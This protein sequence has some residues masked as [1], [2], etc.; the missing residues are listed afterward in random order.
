[1]A[2]KNTC[3]GEQQLDVKE[4][5]SLVELAGGQFASAAVSFVDVG[6]VFEAIE[7][8]APCGSLMSRLASLG[9]N[10]CEAR[11]S[12][13]TEQQTAYEAHV[14]R[15]ESALQRLTGGRHD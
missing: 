13:F 14:D 4:I 5:L 1:M 6:A 12:D 3:A 8:A 2:N 10:L 7:T 15:F 11:E 9:I